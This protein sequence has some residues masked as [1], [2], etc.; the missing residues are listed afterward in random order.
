MSRARYPSDVSDRQ[1]ARRELLLPPPKPGGRPRSTDLREVVEAILAVRR[2]GIVG[3]GLPHDVPPWETVSSDFSPW[4]RAGGWAQVHDRRRAQVRGRDG[5]AP[6][7]RA[8]I[9]ASPSVTTT[10]NGGRA[11]MLSRRA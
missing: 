2:N 3:R 11:A 5:R 6:T 7:P 10:E 1:W 8:A 4:R 9:L